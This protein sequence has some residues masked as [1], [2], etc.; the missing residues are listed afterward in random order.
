MKLKNKILIIA[1]ILIFVSIIGVYSTQY[2]ENVN[3]ENDTSGCCSIVL[4]LNNSDSIM[5][6]RRDSNLNV[7]INIEEFSWNGIPAIKQYKED[8]GHYYHVI[9]TKS[10]WTI[11]LG[12]I[13]DGLDNERC[14]NYSY[15]MVSNEKISNDSLK[16]IQEIKKQYGRGHILIKSPTGDYGIATPDNIQT[17]KLNPGEF[18]SIP[19]NYSYYRSGNM[20]LENPDKIKQMTKLAQTDLYGVDRRDITTYDIKVMENNTTL[21]VYLSNEDGS[22]LGVDYTGCVDDVYINGTLIK[23]SDIPIAPEYKNIGELVLVSDNNTILNYIIMA[24]IGIFI[25]ALSYGVYR[26]VQ[27]IKYKR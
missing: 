19:N 25:I 23:A 4:Q 24:I 15:D 20:S 22:A 16:K 14:V 6:F 12:G 17:G 8:G 10:G 13:D 3:N 26:I 5:T 18:V 27:Y 1:I 7:D 2:S 21:D 11:G 9:I